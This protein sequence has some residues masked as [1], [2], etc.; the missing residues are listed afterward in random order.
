MLLEEF[1]LVDALKIVRCETP[2]PSFEMSLEPAQMVVTS[3]GEKLWRESNEAQDLLMGKLYVSA[4]R[5]LK[6]WNAVSLA[7]EN[8]F[9]RG[10][11][12]SDSLEV[13]VRVYQGS[14]GEVLQVIDEGEGFDYKSVVKRIMSGAGY[15]KGGGKGLRDIHGAP[16]HAGYEGKGNV[17]NIAILY[18]NLE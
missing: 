7:V 5:H 2:V 13:I 9:L 12:G 6:I 17:M 16:V 15:A 8:A 18:Q 14:I 4:R 10:N 3:K 11:R 1:R